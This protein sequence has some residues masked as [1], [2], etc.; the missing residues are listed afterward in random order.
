MLALLIVALAVLLHNV[1]AP[2]A[3]GATTGLTPGGR[4]RTAVAFAVA[5]AALPL[6][7]LLLGRALLPRLP[8]FAQQWGGI[9]LLTAA[10]LWD[11]FAPAEFVAANL[12]VADNADYAGPVRVDGA[13]PPLRLW[14]RA[15]YLSFD[16]AVVGVGLGVGGSGLRAA[17]I[18]LLLAALLAVPAGLALR[19][20]EQWGLRLPRLASYLLLAATAVLATGL[21]AL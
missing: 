5:Q 1:A 3:L 9:T 7:G 12:P 4:R 15:L 6:L 13:A 21:L 17:A 20:P 14:L 19:D 18:A 10:A 8:A 16:N 11:L 2:A